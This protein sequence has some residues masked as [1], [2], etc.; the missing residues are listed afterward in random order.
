MSE[1][2][3]VAHYTIPEE[4]KPRNEFDPG[5][6]DV[7]AIENAVNFDLLGATAPA[8]ANSKL[9]SSAF[10]SLD[11]ILFTLPGYAFDPGYREAYENLLSV[12]PNNTEIVVLCSGS[13]RPAAENL[14]DA[15]GVLART[16]IVETNYNIHFSIWAE[17]A[18]AVVQEAGQGAPT[19]VE[20]ANF[21]RYDDGFIADIVSAQTN[22]G[23]HSVPLYFQGGNILIG[24][25]YWIIG[26]D[27]P[28]KATKLGLITA[29]AGETPKDAAIRRYGEEL[30]SVRT[31]MVLGTKNPVPATSGRPI[32]INGEQWLEIVYF[33]TGEHQPLFHIDMFV[34]L[35]G[36]NGEGA[37]IALVGDP[38]MAA[39]ILGEQTT[40][41]ML[42]PYYD[43]IADRLANEGFQVVR[44]PL[45][46]TFADIPSRKER[47]WYFATANNAL[48]EITNN[49]KRVWLPTYGYGSQQHLGATDSKNK[50]IWEDL[51]FEVV[52]LADFNPFAAKLGA[53][54][55]ICKYLERS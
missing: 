17:D 28:A 14:L 10:G 34:T 39:D 1:T 52:L 19:L 30:D 8:F 25:D 46:L 41:E 26:A 13:M 3:R 33:G 6:S 47:L 42:I 18:Y 7:A 24:D 16:E 11:R 21:T 20:P 32:T 4:L 5:I 27:Y 50:K 35:A 31:M 15:S 44:N 54:H 43:N 40:T 53:V 49:S 55:C 22:I 45:P 51:G 23:A 2:M 9:V 29:N 37:P 12:L 38:K 48:V 36:R